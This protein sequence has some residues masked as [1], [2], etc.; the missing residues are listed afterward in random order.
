MRT[1]QPKKKEPTP[2]EIGV[3]QDLEER[4]MW[5]D[6]SCIH[7][8]LVTFMEEKL[9]DSP[10]AVLLYLSYRAR[11]DALRSD[12]LLWTNEE[13]SRD[14][15]WPIKRTKKAKK[16][17]VDAGL[18]KTIRLSEGRSRLYYI[19]KVLRPH[20]SSPKPN[21]VNLHRSR[22]TPGVKRDRPIISPKGDII[23][24]TDPSWMGSG[25]RK[26]K[27]KKDK[28]KNF[29]AKHLA[30]STEILQQ[31]KKNWPNL[32][33]KL[34]LV[35]PESGAVVLR[36][37]ERLDGY[38]WEEIEVAVKWAISD[39][40]WSSVLLSCNTLR[41]KKNGSS[42]SKFDN[43]YI[44]WRRE[45]GD[46]PALHNPDPK[47]T[48]E[49]FSLIGVEEDRHTTGVLISNLLSIKRT[50]DAVPERTKKSELWKMMEAGKGWTGLVYYYLRWLRGN[51]WTLTKL[52]LGAFSSRS[53]FF[54]KF[55]EGVKREHRIVYL[56][57]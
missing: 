7:F 31:Q 50:Y 40:F 11:V 9:S 1:T 6:F 29:Q 15:S 24:T 14:L 46:G 5:N 25:E 17:L 55:F 16:A 51:P 47:L 42:E 32:H 4:T 48:A 54:Q 36:Q 13:I 39:A 57:N 37:I 45:E 18:V 22:F 23:I 41:N 53:G 56:P 27:Q 28:Q 52:S 44:K 35:R 21:A 12:C 20:F 34:S 10:Y 38:K 2:K 49:I 26:R 19:T 33:H 3:T 8:R 43:I 30:L